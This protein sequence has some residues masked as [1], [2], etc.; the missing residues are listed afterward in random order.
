MWQD[1]FTLQTLFTEQDE[2]VLGVGG[3]GGKQHDNMV[4][5]GVDDATVK[6][7]DVFFIVH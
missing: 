5:A 4:F 7:V 3:G 6:Y 1:V 2:V